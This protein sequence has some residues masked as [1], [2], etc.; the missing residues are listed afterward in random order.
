MLMTSQK[1][2]QEWKTKLVKLVVRRH[3]MVGIAILLQ[4]GQLSR[5]I[6]A[7]ETNTS[8]KGVIPMVNQ[9]PQSESKTIFQMKNVLAKVNALYRKESRSN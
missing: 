1:V 6:Q 3:T 2:V 5:L 4:N 7:Y 9:K 8:I